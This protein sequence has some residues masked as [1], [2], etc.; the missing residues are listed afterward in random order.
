M[1]T[2]RSFPVRRAAATLAAALSVALGAGLAPARAGQV[3]TGDPVGA[4]HADFCPLL[5]A[6]LRLAQLDYPCAASSGTRENLGRVAADPRQLGYGHLD[7]FLL[8]GRLGDTPPL[9]LVRQDDVRVCLYAIT[10]NR[11]VAGWREIA[12]Q[13][14]SLRFVLP[15]EASDSATT[16]GFLRAIDPEALGRAQ[17][18]T[19]TASE[20]AAIGQAL[21]SEDAV[22]FL[23]HLPD[24][25]GAPFALV[26]RLGGRVLPVIDRAILRQAIDDR[27]IYFPQEV[28]VE[29]A[30]W[31]R[32]ARKLVT[33]CTPLVVFTG[34]P[35]RIAG[36]PERKDHED[37]IRTAAALKAGQLM[38]EASMLGHA[39]KRT[40]ELSASGTERMLDLAEGVRLKAKPYTDK[41]VEAA[42][43]VG[44]R[45]RRM[46][47]HAGEAAQKAY[48][49]AVRLGREWAG[50]GPSKPD[51][52]SGQ[53]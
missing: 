23:V 17:S 31:T 33:A 26:R 43:E 52:A 34:A 27:K 4:Y 38:P 1:A 20:V 3:N 25:D 2:N 18:V 11:Q 22:S 24:P 39:L 21:A 37:L 32:S 5:S 42:R 29:S 49:R 50:G 28:E 51:P 13:A 41:A 19:Y 48:E 40:K 12:A 14:G 46:A 10:R 9:T 16:F 36:H 44:D 35:E 47:G 6:Q 53:D 15:P 8:E 7:V 45:A 30:T